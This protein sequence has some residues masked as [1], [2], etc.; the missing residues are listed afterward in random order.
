MRRPM[1]IFG[2]LGGSRGGLGREV[3]HDRLLGRVTRA[4]EMDASLG[5]PKNA[6]AGAP[7]P[8]WRSGART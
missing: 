2:P 1:V 6:T 8:T 3:A 7:L 4:P 5:A